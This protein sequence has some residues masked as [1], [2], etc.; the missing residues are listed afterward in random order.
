VVAE[1]HSTSEVG[2]YC[3]GILEEAFPCALVGPVGSKICRGA[4]TIDQLV[5]LGESVV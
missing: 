5:T 2:K 3:E 4:K 1:V